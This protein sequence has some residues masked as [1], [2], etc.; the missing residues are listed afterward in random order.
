V[1][2]GQQD[3]LVRLRLRTASPWKASELTGARSMCVNVFAARRQTP[4][5]RICVGSRRAQ[6]I[7]TSARVTSGGDVLAPNPVVAVVARPDASTIEATFNP[8]EAGLERGRFAWRAETRWTDDTG[9]PAPDGCV[10][11]LPG[12]APFADQIR[13]LAHPRCF[14]AAARDPRRACRNPALR[15]Q[16][17]PTPSD[18][19]LIPNAFC[20]PQGR[21]GLVSPCAFGASPATA[22]ATIALIGDSHAE[23]WRGALEVVAQAKRWRGLSITRSSCPFARGTPLP[24]RGAVPIAECARWNREVLGWLR[25]HRE[26]HTIVV[27]ANDI[28]N[29]SSS[30][31]AGFRA[32][33]RAL[34]S[35]VRR[36]LVLR[37]TPHISAPQAGC[38]E[39]EIARGRSPDRTC[40]QPRGDNLP[41]DPQVAAARALHSARVRVI[42]MTR[43]MCDAR[44][45]FAVVGGALVRKDGTHL[46]APFA[47]T[48]GPYLLVAIN[49]LLGGQGTSETSP[50][51]TAGGDWGDAQ[52]AG[53]R[54]LA[55]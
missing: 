21:I 40:A 22:R 39:R 4:R 53:E 42:D 27:S 43:Y 33:W 25:R 31:E 17:I 14:G 37:D 26:V 49:R 12:G 5:A 45:C 47:A 18:A 13:L 24:P 6:A 44:V 41:S 9:C 11:R 32:T 23:H 7:L 1:T 28:A 46:T 36:V 34:P 35:S 48:L 16:A 29:Y 8:L 2:F 15:G 52:R 10:D 20:E 51:T 55:V 38:I 50:A 3:T 19:L 30:P 54:P